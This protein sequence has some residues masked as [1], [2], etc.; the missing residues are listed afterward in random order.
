MQSESTST[1]FRAFKKILKWVAAAVLAIF[2]LGSLT[3]L[4]IYGFYAIKDMPTIV[5]EI[6]G[7][8]IGD[9]VSDV[10]FK[11]NGYKPEKQIVNENG[12]KQNSNQIS[13]AN[14][15]ERMY[16]TFE[17]GLVE[18][19]LYDC[20][21]EY[22]YTSI[23]KISCGDSSE[24]IKKRFGNKVRVLC[25]MNKDFRNELRVYDVV[26]YGIRFQLH[27]NKVVGINIFKPEKLNN[28]VCINWSECD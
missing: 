2:T 4:V 10:L 26:D 1:I 19:I 17:N 12:S 22:E 15:N 24:D 28:L 8:A 5:N 3:G 21:K 11:S 9:K 16:V 23:S 18:D 7:V 20:R 13:Y 6:N 14:T 27:Y 25:H